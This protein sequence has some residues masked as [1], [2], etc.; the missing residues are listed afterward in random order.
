[1]VVWKAVKKNGKPLPFLKMVRV[2]YPE[3][4]GGLIELYGMNCYNFLTM[5]DHLKLL[6]LL[7]NIMA[8]ILLLAYLFQ[9]KKRV[10][11]NVLSPLIIYSGSIVLGIT[12][13]YMAMYLDLNLPQ[14][15]GPSPSILPE[16]GVIFLAYVILI[17]ASYSVILISHRLLNRPIHP[18]LK[19]TGTVLVFFTLVTFIPYSFLPA[20]SGL[21]RIADGIVENHGVVFMAAELFYLI[22]LFVL[23]RRLDGRDQKSAAG[24]FSGGACSW[25]NSAR[26]WENAV[27]DT[28]TSMAASRSCS[29]VTRVS[30]TPSSLMARSRISAT[31]ASPK[32]CSASPRFFS[33]MERPPFFLEHRP[34]IQHYGEGIRKVEA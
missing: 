20:Q 24:A 26:A 31:S 8:G 33:V 15:I 1:M 6:G 4:A 32:T 28:P 14:L 30:R 2:Y 25:P 34:G 13:F 16:A 29:T 17:T 27:G 5:T 21:Q 11:E 19:T 18:W 23:S 7:L 3:R 9:K 10:V 22:R 12:L